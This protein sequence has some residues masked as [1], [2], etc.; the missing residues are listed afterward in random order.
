MTKLNN[1]K[2]AIVLG[3]LFAVLHF[4]ARVVDASTGRAITK[5]VFSLHGISLPYTQLPMDAGT[6]IIG[7]LLAAVL[8][9][10]IGWLFAEI[11]NRTN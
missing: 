3:A 9:A 4:V 2:V 1:R 10:A 8:G 5:L 7:T 6:L 11:W